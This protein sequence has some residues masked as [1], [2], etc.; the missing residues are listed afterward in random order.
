MFP[1][2]VLNSWLQATSPH[3]RPQPVL[4]APTMTL[5]SNGWLQRLAVSLQLSVWAGQ[6]VAAW[7]LT[8]FPA[9]SVAQGGSRPQRPL[10]PLVW[11]ALLT[12]LPYLAPHCSVSSLFPPFLG[13]DILALLYHF[14]NQA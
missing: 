14:Q 8:S 3:P 11:T 6:P 2:W 12:T 5:V 4:T 9:C 13:K 1:R 10:P 7:P